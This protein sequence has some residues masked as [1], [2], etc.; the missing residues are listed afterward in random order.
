MLIYTNTP[1]HQH[2]NTHNSIFAVSQKAEYNKIQAAFRSNK[3]NPSF[4]E[5]GGGVAYNPSFIGFLF[6]QIMAFVMIMLLPVIRIIMI[7]VNL[8]ARLFNPSSAN[9]AVSLIRVITV[10]PFAMTLENYRV[11]G[12]KIKKC[13][14]ACRLL[15]QSVQEANPWSDNDEFRSL[16]IMTILSQHAKNHTSTFP[17]R[18]WTSSD[19]SLSP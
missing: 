6:Y 1:I 14:L 11:L 4:T 16:T 19:F 9:D 3:L 17:S 5:M 7:L 10:I 15:F 18:S 12:R 13:F 8:F 2:T